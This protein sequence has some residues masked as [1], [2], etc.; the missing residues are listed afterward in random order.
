MA[1]HVCCAPSKLDD[2]FG[3]SGAQSNLQ[4]GKKTVVIRMVT[5]VSG[6]LS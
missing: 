3:Q 2:Q 6:N 1:V 5:T 4:F